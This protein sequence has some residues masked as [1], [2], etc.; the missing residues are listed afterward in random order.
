MSEFSF[1]SPNTTNSKKIHHCLSSLLLSDLFLLCSFIISHPLYFSYIVF[2]SPY[3]IKILSFLSPLFIT[4]SLLL[5]ALFSTLLR[6]NSSLEFSFQNVLDRLHSNADDENQEFRGF[7]E[8][9]AY[10]IVFDTSI[11]EIRETSVQDSE[12]N[13]L[14]VFEEEPVDKHSI[15]ETRGTNVSQELT[16]E[17]NESL[18]EI[19]RAESTELIAEGESLGGFLKEDLE[20]VGAMCEKGEK[21]VIVKALRVEFN[22]DDH[23]EQKEAT[24]MKGGSK[25]VGSKISDDNGVLEYLSKVRA[26]SQRLGRNDSDGGEY[27]A[28]KVMD[29]NYS[30]PLMGGSNLGS[31][32]SMRKEKEWRRTLAC[33]LFEERHNANGTEGMDSLWETYETDSNKLQTRNKSR[34]VKKGS[35]KYHGEDEDEEEEEEIDD[36]Q[37]CCLQA[38]KFSAG[39]MNLGMGRPNLVKFSKAL[40]G[41][42]WLHHVTKHGKKIYH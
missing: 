16:S 29:I 40:K 28:S 1:S 17:V 10:K 21:E 11:L 31:F 2:F 42:G 8:L 18:A 12:E 22:K 4:T 26:N 9:E 19:M 32:G 7:E 35:S 38:L 37:L 24:A 20:L 23:Q 34:K 33:K 41:I 25:A 36:G 6:D 39:K 3:I 27:Y 14:S 5:L 13:C 30:Q 15:H